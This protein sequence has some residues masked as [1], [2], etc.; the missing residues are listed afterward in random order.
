MN[1]PKRKF[2]DFPSYGNSKMYKG[3]SIIFR[4]LVKTFNSKDVV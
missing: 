3:L 2:E 1:L 4:I